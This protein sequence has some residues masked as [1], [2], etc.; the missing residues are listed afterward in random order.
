MNSPHEA[1]AYAR[2]DFTEVNR[3][4]IE[5]LLDLA[6]HLKSVQALDL[7]TGPAEIPARIVRAC[8]GWHIVALDA[9]RPMLD[10]ARETIRKAGLSSI[11]TL[12]LADAKCTGLAPALFDVIFSNSILHHITDVTRF[13]AEL[14]RIAK[15][16]A[17][18]LV[19]DLV[20]PASPQ[21]ARRIVSMYAEHES[22]LLREE[23]YR[24]LLSAYTPEEIKVQLD[25]AGLS[26]LRVEI[27]SDRHMD[28]VGRLL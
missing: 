15:S 3:A 21:A 19:R 5:R 18:I 28:I 2:A 26:M 11:I 24:S 10:C 16:G 25:C 8:P 6:G 13:W 14:K 12:V 23:Y 22:E 1:E 9:S 27:V 4:F 20:R 17:T 7:G